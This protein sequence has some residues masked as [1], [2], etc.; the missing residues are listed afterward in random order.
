MEKVIT[1]DGSI[2]FINKKTG[3]FYHAFSGA[4][5]EA[6]EK[7]AKAL[8]VDKVKDPVIFDI[9]AG[10]GYNA[11][12]ALDIIKTKATIYLFEDD[13]E[14]I[15]MALE[16]DAPFKSYHHIQ[17]LVRQFLENKSAV[18][19]YEKDGIK[20][21]LMFGDARK[22]ITDVKEKADF[23]FFDPFSPSKTPDMWQEQ[24]FKDINSKSKRG[25]KLAT[26][27][28]AR[29]VR[30]NLIAAGFKVEDGPRWGKNSPTTIGILS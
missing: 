3:D 15:M 18:T 10:M 13:I 28:C 26:Y 17:S 9:C 8:N 6:C 20:L 4:A 24:F 21:V 16:A 22:T 30:N 2:T 7:Y 11:S 5:T 14:I 19:A 29:F 23:I 1:K 12:A 27:S 25:A